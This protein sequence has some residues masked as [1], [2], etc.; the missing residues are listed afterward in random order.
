MRT[1]LFSERSP[2]SP[3][4]DDRFMRRPRQLSPGVPGPHSIDSSWSSAPCSPQSDQATAR[5]ET[6]HDLVRSNSSDDEAARAEQKRA[7]PE[8][9]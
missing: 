7:S 4:E 9:C 3:P 6:V 8:P 2:A 5:Y 1:A